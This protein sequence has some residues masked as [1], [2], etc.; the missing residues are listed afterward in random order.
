M[1]KKS[2]QIMIPMPNPNTGTYEL[3]P[4]SNMTEAQI[5]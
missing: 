1:N 3:I 4:L 2:N 5:I